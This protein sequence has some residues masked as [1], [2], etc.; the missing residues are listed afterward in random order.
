MLIYLKDIKYINTPAHG[1][2]VMIHDVPVESDEPSIYECM[3]CGVIVK[4]TAHPGPCDE[5]GSGFRN[6]IMALE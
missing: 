1:S 4:S 5:C 3:Q 2:I 6:R